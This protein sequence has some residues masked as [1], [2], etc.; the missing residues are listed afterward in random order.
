MAAGYIDN[1]R[2]RIGIV[3]K[4]WTCGQSGDADVRDRRLDEGEARLL[5][6][7]RCIADNLQAAA[8]YVQKILDAQL[9]AYL[10]PLWRAAPHPGA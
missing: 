2:I 7:L 6:V 3:H 8:K 1:Q 10:E 5:E 4:A 9:N